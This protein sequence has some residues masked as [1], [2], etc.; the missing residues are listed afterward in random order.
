L[1]GLILC[2]QRFITTIRRQDNT[3]F[4]LDTI[5]RRSIYNQFNPLNSRP[6]Y[7]LG[8][9]GQLSSFEVDGLGDILRDL[10]VDV[11]RLPEETRNMVM[12]F[13]SGRR[14]VGQGEEGTRRVRPLRVMVLD[15][16]IFR[17]HHVN[18]YS[19]E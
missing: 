14:M 2:K 9:R 19:P 10:D 3:N 8:V 13:E 16:T 6:L 7:E 5:T 11:D 12:G 17:A 1:G 18:L 4:L 15:R